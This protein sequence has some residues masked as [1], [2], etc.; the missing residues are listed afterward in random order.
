MDGMYGPEDLIDS[1]DYVVDNV[2][3]LKIYDRNGDLVKVLSGV[4]KLK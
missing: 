3:E 1:Y 2:R 4:G